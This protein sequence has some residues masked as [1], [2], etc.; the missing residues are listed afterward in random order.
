M[1]FILIL[2]IH[3]YDFNDFIIG[4]KLIVFNLLYYWKKIIIIL[5]ILYLE[6]N[7][8]YSYILLKINHYYSLFFILE[9]K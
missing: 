9:S 8:Y 1:L 2:L 4:C 7:H 6:V 3:H 5:I